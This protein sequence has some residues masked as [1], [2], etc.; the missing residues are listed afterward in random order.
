M[1]RTT[2]DDG[3]AS[4]TAL[5]LAFGALYLVWGSTYL[6]IR[7]AVETIPP[8]L[9]LGAR[10]GFTGLVLYAWMLRRGIE[11]PTPSEWRAAAWTGGLMLFGGTGMVGVAEQH[12]PSGLTALLVST[13][14]LW[15]VLLAWLWKGEPRPHGVVFAGIAIGLA[16]VYFLFETESLSAESGSGP[17]PGLLVLFASLSWSVA[18]I[19]SREGGLPGN[20]FLTSAMQ[21]MAGGAILFVAATVTGEWSQFH[22]AAVTLR[23]A[24]SLAYLVVFGSFIA[25]SAYVWLLRQT[26]PARVS[27]YAFVNPGVAVVLGWLILSEPFTPR[28]AGALALL[29]VSVILIVR[30]G[31]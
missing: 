24:I 15:F 21:M 5:L 11:R 3:R 27:T 9:M 10:F 2:G 22:P 17:M 30:Y 28:I 1:I 6:A 31:R 25:F 26:T 4:L 29:T 13:T 18:S 14:P 23:S 8:F 19:H 12:I 16:G 7:V 20:P